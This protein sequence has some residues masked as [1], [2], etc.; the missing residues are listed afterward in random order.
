VILVDTLGELSAVWGLADL[1]FVGGSLFPGRGG[2]NMMEPAAFGA[3][4]HFGEHT[5]NFRDTVQ[6]LQSRDAATVVKDKAALEQA[7]EQDLIE[8]A[9]RLAKGLRARD[10]VL[11]QVGATVRTVAE[12]ER[13]MHASK[14]TT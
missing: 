3:S 10:L 5:A 2:Q 1:A 9:K 4:V 7:L 14:R 6:L 13:L 11:S 12:L 8:P